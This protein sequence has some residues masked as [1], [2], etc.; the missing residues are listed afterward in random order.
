MENDGGQQLLSACRPMIPLRAKDERGGQRFAFRFH[1]VERHPGKMVEAGFCLPGEAERIEIMHLVV[2]GGPAPARGAG[3]LALGIEDKSRATV[4]QQVGDDEGNALAASR[5]R[6]DEDVLF[7]GKQKGR[8]IHMTKGHAIVGAQGF[9]LFLGCKAR[10]FGIV[11]YVF[12]SRHVASG[13][14]EP[15]GNKASKE[16]RALSFRDK[17]RV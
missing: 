2:E 8:T 9:N 5:A 14:P 7:I 13:E 3:I 16:N 12:S 10:A 6:H 11:G 15:K 1:V 4:A 17:K